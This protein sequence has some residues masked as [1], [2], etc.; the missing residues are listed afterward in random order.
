MQMSLNNGLV[1]GVVAAAC[2]TLAPTPAAFGQVDAIITADNAYM[3]GQGDA[4]G[5][6]TLFPGVSNCLAGEIFNCAD[7]PET[8]TALPITLGGYIYLIGYSDEATTQGII[9]ELTN[10][11]YGGSQVVATGASQPWEVYATGV[12]F[13]PACSGNPQP[14]LADINAAITVANAGGGRSAHHEC[15]LDRHDPGSAVGPRRP[16]VR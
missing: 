1:A 13:D 16:R 14:T 2:T 11:P 5:I 8:Y 10:I 15:R 3:I 4:S 7:G 12:D 9:G 6:T